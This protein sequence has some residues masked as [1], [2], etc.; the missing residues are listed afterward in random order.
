MQD[1]AVW[2]SGAEALSLYVAAVEACHTAQQW[3]Q[4]LLLFHGGASSLPSSGA[5]MSDLAT[6]TVAACRS[7][8]RWELALELVQDGRG[9]GA[10]LDDAIIACA[11]SLQWQLALLG[12]PPCVGYDIFRRVALARPK[13]T[14]EG[15]SAFRAGVGAGGS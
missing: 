9:Q 11:R 15:R 1:I 4:A 8:Q 12:T 13:V 6:A 5:A 2:A 3:E 10:A 7:A 14:S